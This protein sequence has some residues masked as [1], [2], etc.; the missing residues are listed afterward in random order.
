[1]NQPHK[2][3]VL[4]TSIGAGHIRAAQALEEAGKRLDNCDVQVVDFLRYLSPTL[5]KTIEEAYY[6]A[7][8]HIPRVYKFLYDLEDRPA[9]RL[10]KL[11][12]KLGSGKMGRLLL[13]EKPSAVISTH[14][15]P[16]GAMDQL[17]P[18]YSG[19]KTV[20]L[21]DYVP[22]P[23]WLYHNVDLFFVAHE[24][25]RDHL[26]KS[27]IAPHKIKVT[28]IP[29]KREFSHKD[30]K[31]KIRQ[32]LG[33]NPDLPMILMAS[34]GHGIGPMKEMLQRMAELKEPAQVVAIAG[35]NQ[36]LREQLQELVDGKRFPYP[37]MVQG[38][39]ADIHRWMSAADL[40]V[41]K[42]G[43]LTVSEALAVGLPMLVVRPTPGQEDGNTD[44]LLEQGAGIYVQ[45]E[46]RLPL[47]ITGLLRAPDRIY[48]MAQAAQKAAKPDA[49]DQIIQAVGSLCGE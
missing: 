45:D 15:M 6:A 27:G 41:S 21:T 10:K 9:T 38:F 17:Y 49:A 2:I 20:V 30:N 31:Q 16:A 32:E 23:I 37:V 13:K 39:L 43:G 35:N 47:V 19:P 28:G 5:S 14:F 8:K 3:L 46:E 11:Q 29:I 24:G 48:G 4:A 40:M 7:T 34:G 25:M 42:A 26:L 18:A 12:S 33:L 22:H 36:A 44:F 1:M